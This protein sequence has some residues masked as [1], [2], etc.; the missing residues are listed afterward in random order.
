MNE[1]SSP[2]V[3]IITPCYNGAKYLP[4]FLESVLQQ[5][6]K[7]IEFIF[8]DD[9]STDNTKDIVS[10]YSNEFR[11]AG[12]KLVYIYQ[13]NQ[14]QAAAL[15]QG[16]AIFTG[17]YLTWPDSDD[18]LHKDNVK[19]RVEFLEHNPSCNIVLCDSE[20][21]D[22]V[23]NTIRPYK[24]IPPEGEDTIFIDMILQ[25][26]IY[27]AGG[28]Y[29]V[30]ASVFLKCLPKKEIF[31]SQGGQ[32]WQMLLP[33]LYSNECKYLQET[34]YYI[35]EHEDSHSRNLKTYD[36]LLSRTY[37]HEDILIN[38]INSINEIPTGEKLR[39][40][41]I[42]K[43]KY[44]RKRFTLACSFRNQLEAKKYVKKLKSVGSLRLKDKLLYLSTYNSILWYSMRG[45]KRFYVAINDF[46]PKIS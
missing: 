21:V 33:V 34:L 1:N 28:A 42:I 35:V 17:K 14:G 3:S 36:Q 15:N 44:H 24:R 25:R 46:F 12:I 16:L 6:Y 38:T 32:N 4:K 18:I 10:N 22:V 43:G 7:N 39:Y 23:G 19:K 8:I 9:G 41:E 29:M 2:L 31:V 20:I 30:R 40:Q 37:E 13:E 27:Y 5:S 45:L 11:N 26:N